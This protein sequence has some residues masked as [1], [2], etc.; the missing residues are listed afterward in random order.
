MGIIAWIVL[1]AIAGF[2]ANLIVGGRE[3]IIGTIL[4]GIIGAVVGGWIASEVFHKGD[5]NGI[6]IE[7]IIIAVLGAILVLF[8]WRAIRGRRLA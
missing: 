6:N 3:G 4:L 7:S 8:V 5:V 2:I 1:G